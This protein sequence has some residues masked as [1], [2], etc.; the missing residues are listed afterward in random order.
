MRHPPSPEGGCLPLA[1]V[2]GV[3][4][5]FDHY[6]RLFMDVFVGH[7]NVIGLLG[8]T[9]EEGR[10]PHAY[11]FTGRDGVGKKMTALRFACMLNCPTPGT[12]QG[13]EC[14]AC[15]RI[16][17][18]KHPDVYVET[19]ERGMIRIER[20]RESVRGFFRYA[21][22]E[23]RYRIA[24]IDDA[25]LMNQ[26]AQ[27]ALLKTLE[28]PPSACII[29]L[30]TAKPYLLLSTVRSRC[31]RVRFAPLPPDFMAPLLEKRMGLTSDEAFTLAA[32]SG[33]SMSRALEMHGSSFAALREQLVEL[34]DKPMKRGLAG[35][36]EFSQSISGDRSRVRETIEI[37]GTW[38]RDLIVREISDDDRLIINRDSLDRIESSA[39]HRGREE[40]LAAYE[41]LMTAS[42]LIESGTN[43]NRN[44]LT[45]IMLLKIARLLEG[46]T[47]G[48]VSAER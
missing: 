11:L 23:G 5:R 33:G 15:R 16:F 20:I 22:V 26:A 28:E 7:E 1:P 2:I 31:R 6:Q 38:I 19:P 41:E 13:W 24:I 32:M 48:V 40:L 35:I 3:I 10:P 46:P 17:L 4:S 12:D 9:A 25:H 44:L 37:A 14:P 34:L 43:V 36:L 45:D 30:V 21:P 18:G 8:R 47:L 29:V 42:Y 27:N 39:Q